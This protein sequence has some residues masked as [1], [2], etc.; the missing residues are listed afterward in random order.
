MYNMLSGYLDTEQ[1]FQSHN[2]QHPIYSPTPCT[3]HATMV[4]REHEHLS[5]PAAASLGILKASTSPRLG[6]LS[7]PDG[8]IQAQLKYHTVKVMATHVRMQ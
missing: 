1:L 2:P 4:R 5:G 8:S 7:N 6:R 3:Y